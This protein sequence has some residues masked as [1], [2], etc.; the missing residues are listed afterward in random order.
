MLIIEEK[1][2]RTK[3]DKKVMLTLCRHQ[4][5]LLGTLGDMWFSERGK[6]NATPTLSFKRFSGVIVTTNYIGRSRL[7][8]KR[9]F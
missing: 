9:T 3:I 6:D 7:I 5:L 2:R 1:K 8:F 4:R